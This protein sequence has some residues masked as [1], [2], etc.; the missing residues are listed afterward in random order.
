M[1]RLVDLAGKQFGRWSVVRYLGESHWWCR[2]DCGVEKAVSAD[3]LKRGVSKSCGCL[4]VE[5]GRAHGAR[6]KLRHGHGRGSGTAEYRIWS[7]MVS[8]CNNSRHASY[9][10]YG[11]RGIRVC[12]RWLTFENFLADVGLRPSSKHSLDRIDVN[13]GYCPENVRW[14]T[15]TQQARNTTANRHVTVRGETRTLAEWCEL[16][17]VRRE[18]FYQRLR[19]GLSEEEALTLPLQPPGRKPRSNL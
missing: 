7:N 19:R 13:G 17:G 10:W 2:C 15:A 14:A 11:A 5:M 4:R 1:S 9:L 6:V 16:L 18:T 12:E 3:V 8:R